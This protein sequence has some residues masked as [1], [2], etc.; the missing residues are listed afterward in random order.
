M[1]ISCGGES[2]VYDFQAVRPVHG[3]RKTGQRPRRRLAIMQVRDDKAGKQDSGCGNGGE[4][5]DFNS[6]F[7]SAHCVPGIVLGAEHTLI[8]R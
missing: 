5:L 1:P 3:E 8:N 2:L 7:L 4:D 6:H